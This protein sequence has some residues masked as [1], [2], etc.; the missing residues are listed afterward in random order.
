MARA[1]GIVALGLVGF[2]LVAHLLWMGPLETAAQTTAMWALGLLTGGVGVA[3][4]VLLAVALSVGGSQPAWLKHA[5]GARNAA[6][7]LGC[8]LIVVGLVHYRNTEPSGEIH[9]VVL[10]MVVLGGSSGS[11]AERDRGAPRVS[12][13]A[14][15]IGGVG[16]MS[17]P[18]RSK[19]P[20]P[21]G[22][23]REAR[24]ALAALARV[25][26]HL[27]ELELSSQR[28]LER[29][30]LTLVGRAA[31][32]EH[33]ARRERG[34][35]RGQRLCRRARL[36]PGHDAVGEADSLRFTGI[37]GATREDQ[38]ERAAE[39]DQPRQPH[40]PAV[41]QWHA[42]APAEHTE[43]GVLL[44]HAQIAPERQL[45]RKSVV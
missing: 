15:N 11:S 44:Q 31:V 37:Y 7:V 4:I 30:A 9:W 34:D 14:P 28:R 35:L 19:S 26:R 38:I 36:A 5:R 23:G 29:D 24:G 41:D 42:P 33:A 20:V 6:A 18:P 21:P 45:D 43:H 22:A 10:G 27:A 2:W 40:G 16:A 12:R 25:D 8:A 39:A 3:A 17:G 32:A 13:G 1:L